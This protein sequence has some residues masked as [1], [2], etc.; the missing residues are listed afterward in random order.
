[1]KLAVGAIGIIPPGKLHTVLIG[2]RGR[3]F[4]CYAKWNIL[5]KNPTIIS[6]YLT[7]NIHKTEQFNKIHKKMVYITI[8]KMLLTQ[9]FGESWIPVANLLFTLIKNNI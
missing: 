1:M 8:F 5:Y 2:S 3:S 7:K 4:G 9:P 6:H